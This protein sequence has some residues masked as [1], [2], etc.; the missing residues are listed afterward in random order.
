MSATS[1]AGK[2]KSLE[3][4]FVKSAY[5]DFV[6]AEEA[7]LFE[8]SALEDLASLPLADW[9][10]RGGKVGYTRLGEQEEYNL[11]IVEIPPGGQLRPEHHM[12]DALM[13]VMKGSG[14]SSIWQND[15]KKRTIEWQEG[16]LLAI[17][18]N[19]WHQEF[20]SSGSDSCRL[21]FAT[22]MAY[23]MNHYNNPDFIFN[24]PYAFTDRYSYAMENF[25]AEET[26]WEP[27]VLETNFIADVRKMRLDPF[28][29]RGNRTSIVRMS[30][31]GTSIGMHVMGV[32]EGTY[33]TAH[34]HGPGAH[35]IVV[36]GEGYELLFDPGQE[37]ERKRVRANPYAVVAPK[38]NEFH[39]HFN[40]G[41]GEYR[42]LAFRNTGLRFGWG[43]AYNRARTVQ[44][45]DPNAWA[46]K[47]PYE[48]EDPAI[49]E[50]Y[51]RTLEANGISLRLTPLDQD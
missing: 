10:R 42:M 9:K 26:Q 32:S 21:L 5:Q 49:S 44:S 16:S 43:Q 17:P 39:Q 11:Q 35:V 25:L 51:Y 13:F 36:G 3:E 40:T 41:K 29:E 45:K 27:R 7:P 12:Y 2:P 23:A 22:N 28:P 38:R 34:R 50:E 4:W 30:M 15:E 14:V 48:K 46:F 37:A 8:G 31:A 47:I 24:C 19:A 1:A 6:R 18:L 33:V 20:N